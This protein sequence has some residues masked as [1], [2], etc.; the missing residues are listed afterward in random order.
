MITSQQLTLEMKEKGE[1][2]KR[3]AF[4]FTKDPEEIQ[5][6]VQQTFVLSLKC[7]D[8]Y[9]NNPKLVAWL[10]VIMKNSYINIYR[11]NQKRIKFEKY[12]SSNY[13]NEGCT[14]PSSINEAGYKFLFS[15]MKSLLKKYPPCYNNL[16][17]S[18]I[19]GYKYR[20]LAEK[21]GLPEGT[22]KTRIYH[23]RKLLQKNLDKRLYTA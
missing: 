20:E 23:M 4:K 18:Y 14:E 10:Y 16:F 1:I 9:I 17:E 2:L 6:F 19:E 3:L 5:E 8:N 12:Q 13:R 11:N 15:D 21:Y 7:S 22:V